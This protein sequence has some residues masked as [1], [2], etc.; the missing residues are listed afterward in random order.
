MCKAMLNSVDIVVLSSAAVV[1][2][3]V[4][5][6]RFFILLSCTG[7]FNH[8]PSLKSGK[9]EIYLNFVQKK[10][11]EYFCYQQEKEFVCFGF[12][13][14][15]TLSSLSSTNESIIK[16]KRS[17]RGTTDNVLQSLLIFFTLILFTSLS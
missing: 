14:L 10:K 17:S 5:E 1:S 4:S 6:A 11:K 9:M 15:W 7:I 2:I 12:V 8:P 3:N 13:L 16:T